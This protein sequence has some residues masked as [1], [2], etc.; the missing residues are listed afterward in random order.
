MSCLHGSEGNKPSINA[1]CLLVLLLYFIFELAYVN[2][3]YYVYMIESVVG[4]LNSLDDDIY[5]YF[6][7]S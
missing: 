7:S 3:V 2:Q 4:Y 6:N 1:K 5:Q